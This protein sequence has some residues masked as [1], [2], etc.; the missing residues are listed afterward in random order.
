MNARNRNK[1]ITIIM[2]GLISVGLL[3]SVSIG[4]WGGSFSTPSSNAANTT[5]GST[6]YLA[7]Q[8]FETALTLIQKGKSDEA[9]KRLTSAIKGYEEVLKKTPNNIQVLGDLATAYFYMG[10]TDKAIELAKK[11]LTIQPKYSTVR[12]NY[13]KYL[14]Y[15]KNNSAEALK[16]LKKIEKGDVNYQEAQS[17]I[18][19]INKAPGNTLPPQG[20]T[21]PPQGNSLPLNK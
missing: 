15:G 20:N 4:Y 8:D 9:G 16:E 18:A 7:T 13:A 17:L 14:F 3:A 19:D 10:N 21:L 12:V 2:V 5:S 11:A 6:E 1:T